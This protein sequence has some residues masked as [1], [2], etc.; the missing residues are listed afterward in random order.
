M[1]ISI[2]IALARGCAIR[3]RDWPQCHYAKV[4]KG[5]DGKHKLYRCYPDDHVEILDVKVHKLREEDGWLIL[6]R[7]SE[8]ALPGA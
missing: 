5:S 8:G 3:H 1:I 7:P 2:Q 4:A 6:D